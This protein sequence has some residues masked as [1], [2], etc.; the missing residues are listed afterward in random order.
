MQLKVN[1]TLYERW[2]DNRK[3]DP[4]IQAVV[5]RRN[6]QYSKYIKEKLKNKYKLSSGTDEGFFIQ[7]FYN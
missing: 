6:L 7:L 2:K 1:L 5:Q 3:P 4:L